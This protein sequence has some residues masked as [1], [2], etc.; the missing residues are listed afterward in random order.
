MF[1]A[2]A[3]GDTVARA[4]VDRFTTIL[5]CGI[6]SL[7]H[8]Y[9]AELVIIGGGLSGSAGQFLPDLRRYV[10]EHAWTYP[11]DRVRI[12]VAELGDAAALIG[13]AELAVDDSWAW[14]LAG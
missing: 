14:T 2:A 9:G 12:E 5:G 3:A 8:A 1:A 4:T 11:K 10:S 6:V 13:A 7:V